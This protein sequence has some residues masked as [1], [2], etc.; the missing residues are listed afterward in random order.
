MSAVALKPLDLLTG[1]PLK[2]NA[3]ITSRIRFDAARRLRLLSLYS[4]ISLTLLS[5]YLIVSNIA[6]IVF[7]DYITDIGDKILNICNIAVS[8]IMIVVGLV[9]TFTSKE[10]RAHALEE[11]AHELNTL[12]AKIGALAGTGKLT[13]DRYEDLSGD[14]ARVLRTAG[15]AHSDADYVI[16]RAN[17]P[18]V[19]PGP[20]P[21]WFTRVATRAWRQLNLYGFY[22]FV[23]L[24][25]PALAGLALWLARGALFVAP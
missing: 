5:C 22:Y 2:E 16:Y 18:H 13:A 21:N 4:I 1:N 12:C 25:L 14:Y 15:V 10:V 3:Y 19:F 23:S 6:Q 8:I 9:E 24:M 11:N 20:R 17:N 7:G